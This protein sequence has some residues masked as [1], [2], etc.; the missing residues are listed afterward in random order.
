[1][2][3]ATVSGDGICGER[4]M[5]KGSRSNAKWHTPLGLLPSWGP[6]ALGSDPPSRLSLSPLLPVSPLA[7]SRARK[8]IPKTLSRKCVLPFYL[9]VSKPNRVKQK[10]NHSLCL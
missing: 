10:I 2:R 5:C 7:F 9:G 1:M 4:K 6:Q 8:P 3:Q